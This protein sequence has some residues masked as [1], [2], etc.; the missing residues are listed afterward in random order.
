MARLYGWLEGDRG[1]AKTKPSNRRLKVTIAYERDKKDWRILTDNEIVLTVF[2]L[3][4]KARYTLIHPEDVL[5][6]DPL[7]PI[8]E[9]Q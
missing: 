7:E 5:E 3:N 1:L 8:E 6:Y 9:D 2:Y 4:G